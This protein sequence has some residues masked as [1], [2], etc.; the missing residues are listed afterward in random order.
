MA[1]MFL[2]LQHSAR[3]RDLL[4][5]TRVGARIDLGRVANLVSDYVGYNVED[6]LPLIFWNIP[7]M[8]QLFRVLVPDE[9]ENQVRGKAL[10]LCAGW[11]LWVSGLVEYFPALDF[12]SSCRSIRHLE[13]LSATLAGPQTKKCFYKLK[14]EVL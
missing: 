9:D 8:Q 10:W 3:P 5:R 12:T 6:S 4:H 13:L 2:V 14:R 1:T 7:G 11:C